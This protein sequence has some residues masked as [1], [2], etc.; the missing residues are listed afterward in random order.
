MHFALAGGWF[1]VSPVVGALHAAVPVTRLRR[2]RRRRGNLAVEG[3]WLRADLRDRDVV[4]GDP[5]AFAQALAA[6]R[7]GR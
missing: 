4:E 3:A 1:H 7:E 2:A 6:A 5:V